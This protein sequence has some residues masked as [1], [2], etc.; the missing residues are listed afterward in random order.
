MNPVIVVIEDLF[1]LSK[2]QQTAK[3]AGIELEI[4]E[5]EKLR[6][7]LE[8][9]SSSG[10]IVDL[11]HKSG[12]AIEAIR[13]LKSKSSGVQVLGFLSHVQGNLAREARE[14]GCDYVLARSAFSQ[15]LTLWFAKLA[16]R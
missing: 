5:L 15:D 7:R 3:K 16:G 14:A 6:E 2:V 11:N 8:Q 10:V 9:S 12:N 1:F 13:E 4:V